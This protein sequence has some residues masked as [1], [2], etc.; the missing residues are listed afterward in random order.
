M[1]SWYEVS[2]EVTELCRTQAAL[3]VT[4][5]LES[6]AKWLEDNWVRNP[7]CYLHTRGINKLWDLPD[8]S[9]RFDFA[10]ER[11]E[12]EKLRELEAETRN[13]YYAFRIWYMNDFDGLFPFVQ[14][15][16]VKEQ[17]NIAVAMLEKFTGGLVGF[18]PEFEV[19][20]QRES[21]IHEFRNPFK[22]FVADAVIETLKTSGHLD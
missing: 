14:A 1:S 5:K 10:T 17:R 20:R 18:N 8:G 11:S 16:P 15:C 3:F 6:F 2:E 12:F 4:P 22:D 13:G 9:F 19:V 21:T 7:L